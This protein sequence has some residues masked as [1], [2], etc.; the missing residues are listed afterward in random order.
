MIIEKL[1]TPKIYLYSIILITNDVECMFSSYLE[2]RASYLEECLLKVKINKYYK[3]K[4]FYN[5]MYD[6]ICFN[7]I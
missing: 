1:K 2:S 4:Y 7:D 6:L 5:V 3:Y